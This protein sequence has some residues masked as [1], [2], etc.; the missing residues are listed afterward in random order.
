M[1]LEHMEQAVAGCGGRHWD[2]LMRLVRRFALTDAAG[3][4]PWHAYGED[5]AQALGRFLTLEMGEGAFAVRR[6]KADPDAYDIVWTD[7]AR[8]AELAGRVRGEL[9]AGTLGL[10]LR[11]GERLAP[12]APPAQ[13]SAAQDDM[14]APDLLACT[15]ALKRRFLDVVGGG[16]GEDGTPGLVGLPEGSLPRILDCARR[17]GGAEGPGPYVPDLADIETMV[18]ACDRSVGPEGFWVLGRPGTGVRAPRTLVRF[19]KRGEGMLTGTA[20][21]LLPADFLANGDSGR[22]PLRGYLAGAPADTPREAV[23][24]AQRGAACAALFGADVVCQDDGTDRLSPLAFVADPKLLAG[25]VRQLVAGYLK[26]GG[27]ADCAVLVRECMLLTNRRPDS[28]VAETAADRAAAGLLGCDVGATFVSFQVVAAQGVRL[29]DRCLEGLPLYMTDLRPMLVFGD[30]GNVVDA[31]R[32]SGAA[33]DELAHEWF[34]LVH[35]ASLLTPDEGRKTPSEKKGRAALRARRRVWKGGWA[36]DM[37]KCVNADLSGVCEPQWMDSGYSRGWRHTAVSRF[38]TKV[39]EILQGL[40]G[41]AMRT[42]PPGG[43]PWRG[44]SG[45]VSAVYTGIVTP[46]DARGQVPG[47]GRAVRAWLDSLYRSQLTE[48]A[49]DG[50]PCSRML[51]VETNVRVHGLSDA[52]EGAV[53]TRLTE[54]ARNHLVFGFGDVSSR[55][56]TWARWQ[57][58]HRNAVRGL[59]Y[60]QSTML[61]EAVSTPGSMVR[62]DDPSCEGDVRAVVTVDGGGR[63][64]AVVFLRGQA[65]RLSEVSMRISAGLPALGA[66][67]HAR[68]TASEPGY[69]RALRVPVG[70]MGD[71]ALANEYVARLV[72]V[73]S[74]DNANGMS[75]VAT[76]FTSS[77]SGAVLPAPREEYSLTMGGAAERFMRA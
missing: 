20:M 52:D 42:R 67:T 7:V 22:S 14:R 13:G 31:D 24:E 65:R 5:Q 57:A 77:A 69:A 4:T 60:C 44:R 10:W 6:R 41:A 15:E 12:D 28:T 2:E 16:T 1:V 75:G 25:Y 17:C 23:A 18:R 38:L 47:R 11:R 53:R 26:L 35:T 34:D 76:W 48:P 37:E 8:C 59:G 61:N 72:D 33:R 55:P 46:E 36:R 63:L 71:P 50:G 74:I 32:G 62:E 45:L 73:R 3:F 54:A 49:C 30:G 40:P 70:G 29:A 21:R 39:A 19:M 56:V 51:V 9:S 43:S 66:E 64:V 58:F 68:L 27:A